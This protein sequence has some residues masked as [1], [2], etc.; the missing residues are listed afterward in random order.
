MAL[1]R[2]GNLKVSGG[3]YKAGLD[4]LHKA[5]REDPGN[6]DVQI[7]L[8]I[9]YFRHG[10]YANTKA[11][12]SGILKTDPS[13]CRARNLLGKSDFLAHRVQ[14]RPPGPIEG[15]PLAMELFFLRS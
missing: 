14:P 10:D 4:L 5:V 6:R 12:V 15:A 2:L 1:D 11:S 3:D 7:D 9:A 13:N 8:G